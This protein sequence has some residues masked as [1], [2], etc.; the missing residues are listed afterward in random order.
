M[1]TRDIQA[2]LQEMYGVEVSPTLISNV[3]D[4]VMDE[5][6]QWQNRPLETVYPIAYFDCL[7]VKVRDNGRVVNKAV[8]LALGVDL[9][10]RKELLGLWLSAHE[11]AKFWLGILTE[12]N[13]R[14]LKDILIA[15]VDGLTGLPEA[16]ES[17]YHGCLVQLC[18][19]HMVRNSCKY[20]SWKDRKSLCADLRSIYSAATEEEAELHLGGV[21]PTPLELLSEKWDKQYSSVSRMWR[22]NWGSLP[23]RPWVR[24]IPIFRFGEDIR[25]V[26]YTTN[27]I[28]SLNMT[29]RKVSRNHHIMPNDES[30]MK[31]VYL[32]IQ[33]QMKKWTMPIRD[34]RPALNRLT[35]EFEGRLKV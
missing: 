3:T 14:G 4:A 27:A 11:G 21:V 33:N 34:W 32:A 19:V 23:Q 22:E 20:V 5:V 26:I 30:V 24:V 29:I 12:L 18:M 8:Y 35:I 31:M 10:G 15:C 2:Q 28:E 6:R 1:T 17:V 25:K 16:I 7:Q 13:N 9:E